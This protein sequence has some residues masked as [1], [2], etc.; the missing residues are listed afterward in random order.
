MET[1]DAIKALVAKFD[2]NKDSYLRSTYN[3]AQVRTEFIDPLF[4]ALG[5]DVANRQGFAEAYKEV[6]H[7]DAVKIGSATKAPD[8]SFRIG[9]VRKFFVEAKKPSVDIHDDPSPAFQLRRYAWSAKLPLSV[10]TDFQ[11]FAVYDCRV[12][13]AESDKPSV[14]RLVYLKYTDY[15]T[16]WADVLSVFSKDGLLRGSFDKFAASNRVKKGTTEVDSAFLDEIENWRSV[17]AHNIALRNPRLSQRELNFAVQ[18]TIDRLIFLRICEDRG[19]ED[20]GKLLGHLNG[21]N[22]YKRLCALFRDA[23]GRYN[24]GLFH[25]REEKGRDEAPDGLTLSLSID[26]KVLKDLIRGMYYPDSPYEFSVLPADILGQVYEQFL[27]KVIRLTEGHQARVEDKPEVKKAGGVY[28]TPTYIVEYIVKNTVG[29]LLEGK[30]PKEAAKL[31]ILDPA[32]GSGSFLIGAYQLLLDWHRDWYVKDN[33]ERWTK[34][35][36][37]TLYQTRANEHRLTAGERKRILL[38]SIHGVDIDPQAAEVTKL[39]LLL[40][41]LE[42]ENEQSLTQQLKL[43]HE[44]ALPDLENNIK[45]GN[46]LIG[47]DFYRQQQLSLL[48]DEDRYRINVFNWQTEFARVFEAG[49]FD[50]VVGNPPYIRIQIMKETQP[51]EVDFYGHAYQAARQGNYDIYVVFVERCLGLLNKNGKLGFILPNKFFNAQYGLPLREVLSGGRH[52]DQIV[53]FGDQQ[54]FASATTYTCLLF[55][56]SAGRPSCDITKVADVDEWRRSGLGECAKLPAASFGSAEWNIQVG[57]KATL[58]ARMLGAGKPLGEVADLFVGL[59]T[60]ADRIFVLPDKK[61]VEARVLRP[62][63]T[64]GGLGPYHPAQANAWLLF[65]YE[66]ENGRATLIPSERMKREFPKAWAYLRSH[67][68]MLRERDHGKWNHDQWYA[69]GRSQNLTEMDRDKLVIQVTAIRPTVIL[70]RLGLC[71]TGGG[72][73]PF[74]GIRPLPTSKLD[75][76]FLL[77]VLNS[78]AFGWLVRTQ[79]TP[80]RGGYVK[81]SK[82]YIETAPIPLPTAAGAIEVAQLADEMLDLNAQVGEARTP[83]EQTVLTRRIETTGMRIDRL[84][85]GLYG[86]TDDEIRLVEEE[87]HG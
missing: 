35:K 24:S 58:R 18:R 15:E 68:E 13:P 43:F 10:L 78:K 42:G 28:Y 11:E 31:R 33:A 17:F 84:V 64:T 65:P 56:S 41:V 2:Q 74:Y 6:I 1:I 59:Q 19:I 80:L 50:V 16:R 44:R 61:E 75:I 4:E 86:L 66:I 54:I 23:D 38:N 25:F 71:M 9:G 3:E 57:D 45:C 37:P 40:K 22:V 85:C 55:L 47:P 70:D 63:L 39:S 8:Y 62:F 51:E 49:G 67:E 29:K 76:K 30:T 81:F 27:G 87:P 7:E 69:F 77:G 20:Y 32:C 26:D 60:S 53:H 82:Q 46:S 83:Q 21:E 72:A 5:W 52:L 79:S 34:G 48:S 73:G 36:S 12:K 14:G